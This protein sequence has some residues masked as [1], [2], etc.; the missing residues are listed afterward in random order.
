MNGTEPLVASRLFRRAARNA[1]SASLPT[2]LFLTH[3]PARSRSVCLTFDDGPHPVHTPRL[4]DLLQERGVRA[5]F[6]VVG[7]QVE[8]YPEIVRRMVSAGHAVG[9][10]TFSHGDPGAVTSRQLID[11]VRRTDDLLAPILGRVPR[12]FRPPH[13]K[14]T[15]SKLFRLWG[16][17]RTVVLWNADPK[18]YSRSD[19]AEVLGWFGARPLRGGDIVLMHDN[20]P[21][22]I[23]ALP[24]LIEG[25]HERGL[26][27]ATPTDWIGRQRSERR[28]EGDSR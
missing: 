23:D 22:S 24:V 1:L 25:A 9:N 16:A 20:I 18:D 2:R 3:G 7:R 17:S 10:H 19:A 4:L 15:A 26:V 21:H 27:F 11:E 12:L 13:G 5:T 8:R 28:M 6:F 14:V